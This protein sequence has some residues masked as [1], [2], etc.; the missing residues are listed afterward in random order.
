ML[1]Q[2]IESQQQAVYLLVDLLSQPELLPLFCRLGGEDA[3]PLFQQAEFEE[4]KE[5]GPW[6]LPLSQLIKKDPS[7]LT[8]YPSLTGVWLSSSH[9]PEAISK[10]LQSLL[11]AV[12]E[13]EA[14]L[15]RYYDINVLA[16]FLS[17]LASVKQEEFM[18]P[19]HHLAMEHDQHWLSF[20]NNQ[21]RAYDASRD[22]PWW[23]LSPEQLASQSNLPRHVYTIERQL[24]QQLHPLMCMQPMRKEII[25]S[26]IISA[27]QE[28]MDEFDIPMWAAAQLGKSVNYSPEG[29]VLGMKLNQQDSLTLAR[30]MESV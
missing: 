2:W 5:K 20:S 23:Y 3:Q 26:A 13:G 14:V 19:I 24:W 27:K 6:L 15:F 16:P 22:A 18:G 12:Y 30:W 7:I 10:H 4:H 11:L 8:K 28:N 29:I 21:I 25:E 1:K 17:S 9:S